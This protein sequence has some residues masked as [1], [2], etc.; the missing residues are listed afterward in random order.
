METTKDSK[1]KDHIDDI[2]EEEEEDHLHNEKL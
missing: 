1:N 2:E